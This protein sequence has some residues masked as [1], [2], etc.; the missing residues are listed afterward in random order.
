M[1]TFDRNQTKK[2]LNNVQKDGICVIKNVFKIKK[3]EQFKNKIEKIYKKRKKNFE[4]V[5]STNNQ[6]IYNFFMED[7]SLFKL[8]S[9]PVVDKLLKKLIDEDYVLQ[10]SNAQN[11]LIEKVISGKRSFKIGNKWH[12]DSRYINNKRLS[13]GFSYL[14]VVALEDFTKN[15]SATQYVEGSLNNLKKPKR[16]AKYKCKKLTMKA[17]SICIMD[18]GLWHKGGKATSISRWSIFNIFTPWFV[19]P[20]FNYRNMLG[21][22]DKKFSIQ[23]KKIL[24]FFSEPPKDHN[25]RINTLISY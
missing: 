12:T 25:D 1:K 9:I 17:G 13:K 5:G 20:Y 3:M 24:H 10:S 7:K 14:V 19:K 8:I 4:S 18:T 15:N 21:K 6:C 23:E 16:I 11:R 2:I 22:K